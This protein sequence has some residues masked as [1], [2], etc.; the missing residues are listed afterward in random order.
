M[1]Q[2]VPKN[3]I[4]IAK[5]GGTSVADFIAMN[6][7]INLIIY[8]PK[9]R[10]VVLSASANVTNLLISLTKK[11]DSNQKN[12]FF[13]K[14]KYIQYNILNHI[15]SPILI[16]KKIDYILKKINILSKSLKLANSPILIDELM[17][18]GELMSTLLFVEILRN[19]NIKV[20]WFDIRKIMRTND[21]FGYAKP[22]RF[23][24]HI[25]TQALLKPYLNKYLIVTQ[26]FIGSDKNGRT[27]TLG[28]NGSDYTA[29][30]LGEALHVS[31]VNIWTDVS[32]IYTTDPHIVPLAKRINKITFKEAKEMAIYGA[33]ILHPSTLLPALRSN[34]P[35]FIGSSKQPNSGGTLICKTIKNSPMFRAL[36][37]RHQQILLTLRSL[38]IFYNNG[39]INEIF[40][41][42]TIYDISINLITT[43]KLN[44]IFTID[45]NNY[46]FFTKK[47]LIN[48]LFK[49][50][51]S[52]CQLKIE[53]NLTLITLIGNYLSKNSNI[54]NNI[55]KILHPFNI[56]M[57]YYISNNYN[58]F[59]LVHK[60]DA[61]LIIKTLHYNI[62]EKK[63]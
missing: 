60:K 49:K 43:S 48:S 57:I 18:Y 53:K 19:R 41:I 38:N 11:C 39:F 1:I 56:R 6:R 22:N 17:S 23:I 29:M 63:N 33:K 37:L 24:L 58:L 62:F 36:T 50:L 2:I 7:S 26:G 45:T 10:L 21:N 40:K 52:I 12:A 61:E 13:N 55:L 28:R 3:S 27:T 54:Y 42:L 31:Q 15:N 34:I 16:R 9:I 51:S 30:L 47:L 59:F 46:T 32:G 8:N 14:I 20:K 25:L 5:F 44:I 35:I 4:I